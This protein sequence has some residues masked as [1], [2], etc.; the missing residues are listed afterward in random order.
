MTLNKL[1]EI[2]HLRNDNLVTPLILQYEE[3]IS[4]GFKSDYILSKMRIFYSK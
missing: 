2:S 4:Y 1:L 3:L